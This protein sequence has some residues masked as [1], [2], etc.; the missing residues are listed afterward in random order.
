MSA[1]ILLILRIALA[2]ALYA[3]LGWILITIWRDIKSQESRLA[4]NQT[5]PIRL[6]YQEA[7]EVKELRLTKTEIILGRDPGCDCLLNDITVS[8]RHACLSFHHQQ[9]WL[10]DLGSTNGTL[11]N[12]EP[13]S[14]PMVVVSGDQITCGKISVTIHLENQP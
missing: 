12:Q 10:E 3:F 2:A 13:I 7:E 6:S 8:N 9:W 14:T 1:I 4:S 11:L 5:N